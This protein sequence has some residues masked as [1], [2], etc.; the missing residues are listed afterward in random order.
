MI[1]LL[2]ASHFRPTLMVTAIATMLAVSAGRGP[3]SVW[4]A[5]AVLAGQLSVGWSNDY[6]DR[7]RDRLARRADKPIVAGRVAAK[8]VGIGAVV[9]ALVCVPLSMMS[10][11]RAGLVHLAAVAVAWTYNGW[12]QSTVASAVPYTVAFGLLPSFV[13]LGLP[14]HPRPPA[15]VTIAAA[16]MGTGAHFVNTLPDFAGDAATGVRGLT[17]RV[18]P[19]VSLFSAALLMA[20]ATVVI[21]VMPS[22]EPGLLGSALVA[23]VSVAIVAVVVAGLT[24]HPRAAWTLT[25][26]VALL[27]V[28]VIVA[29]GGWLV[30]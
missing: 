26:C 29:R 24:D 14:E 30:A 21:A 18:G 2:Q 1:S 8:T 20:A 5:L 13:T 11:W 23:G 15:W 4:V 7:D 27:N 17:Q 12:L 28:M 10:G 19:G 16:L 25:L 22:G 9:A 3:G 6:L